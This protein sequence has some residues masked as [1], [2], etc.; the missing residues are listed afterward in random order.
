MKNK[1]LTYLFLVIVLFITLG[2]RYAPKNVN[3]K[4]T[5]TDQS[6]AAKSGTQG[7]SDSKSLNSVLEKKYGIS[8]KYKNIP[9]STWPDLKYENLAD[10]DSFLPKYLEIFNSEFNKYSQEFIKITNL[11]TVA[12][13]KKLTVEGQERAAAP[14][15]YKEILFL[16]IYLG[17]Y[18]EQ[19]QRHVIHHE[20]YHMIEEQLNGNA[21]YKD[22]NW[23]AFNPTD[24]SY[25]NGGKYERGDNAFPLTHPK[26]G[27]INIYSQSAL[28]ED[29]AEIY[30]TLFIK[31]E[32]DKVA[33]WI[34]EGDSILENKV[35]YMKTFLEKNSQK[36]D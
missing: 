19:Y 36:V 22:P 18:D 32:G 33:K 13:V 29:K 20:F 24:F 15:Y 34:K 30:A 2:C 28:E 21:Y 31:D 1:K 5:A 16:D 4:D 10:D 7:A 14:D 27:F 11:K 23:A 3:T 26:P 8:L 17:N 6:T 9:D 12:F 25:G 35:N